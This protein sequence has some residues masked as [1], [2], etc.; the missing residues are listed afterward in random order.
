MGGAGHKM[1][2][3]VFIWDKSFGSLVKVL[4]GPRESLI[5]CDVRWL[6]ALGLARQ[7]GLDCGG[8]AHRMLIETVASHST[9][10]CVCR[11]LGGYPSMAD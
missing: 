11:D 9:G 8:G 3:N 2:H 1:A 7:R 5:D 4:E 6:P 10:H